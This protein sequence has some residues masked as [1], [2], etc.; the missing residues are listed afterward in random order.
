MP[1]L[2]RAAMLLA[3]ALTFSGCDDDNTPLTTPT[4][5]PTTTETFSGMV[6]R[7]GAVTHPF[8]TQ[9]SG[10]VSATLTTL[11]PDSAL[12]VGFSMGTWNGAVCQIV[13]ANDSATQGTVVTGGASALGSLCMRI[14]DVGNIVDP[15]AYE[16]TVVHP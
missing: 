14:Y 13:L 3:L 2:F 4:P 11:S 16:F 10:T 12:V 8:S 1:R 15:I 9:A 6:N 7:N 5:P